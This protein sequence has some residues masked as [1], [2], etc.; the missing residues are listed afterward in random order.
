MSQSE[1]PNRPVNGWRR[2][3]YIII[4]EA[5]TY[6]GRFFDVVLLWAILMSV[7]LVILESVK[8]LGGA[9]GWFFFG[10]EWVFTILFSL[11][12][13]LRL[14]SSRRPSRYIFSFFGIV[15]LVSI[16]PSYIGLMVS[17]VEGLLVVRALRLLR[18]FR[19]FKVAR[20][21]HAGSTLVSALKQGAAKITVFLM[22]VLIVVLI[23]GTVM[24]IV[25]GESHGFTSIPS[26]MY[27]VVVT[28]T[29]VGYG[30]MVPSTALGQFLASVI[31]LLG[32]GVIAVPTGI[33]A[34]EMINTDTNCPHCGKAL[35]GAKRPS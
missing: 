14:I 29:T 21:L 3:L 4:F 13:V 6:W 23:M 16:L 18:V 7:S 30:D 31:M 9:Y 34:R 24:Y 10:A 22:A 11:E 28:M 25:E 35:D 17:G 33:V 5:E 1:D 26:S 8:S 27:W 32:Y 12:F 15:D 20:F 2:E 19:I